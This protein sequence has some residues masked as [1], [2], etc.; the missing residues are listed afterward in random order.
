M[1]AAE[2]EFLAENSLISIVP[3]FSH[4]RLYFISGVFGPFDVDVDTS[5]PLWLAITL[6][7]KDKCKIVVPDW[8]RAENLDEAVRKERE[9]VEFQPLPFHYMEIAL[10]LLSCARD[11]IPE[12][13]RVTS[14]LQNLENIRKD[15][16]MIGIKTVA[17]TVHGGYAVH[18]VKLTNIGALE[19][20]GIKRF[21]SD[22]MGMFMRLTMKEAEP[23][24]D[25]MPRESDADYIPPGST[26]AAPAP[27]RTLRKLHV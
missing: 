20:L 15:R 4:P 10:L 7:K 8:L 26:E 12:P 2:N 6:R 3:N 9:E 14:L 16:V 25:V 19:I 18:N 5:V 11:E 24:T 13:D 22:S 1:T 27:K 23:G 17:S 21:L